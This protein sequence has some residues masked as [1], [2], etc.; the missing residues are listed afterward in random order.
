MYIDA[1]VVGCSDKSRRRSNRCESYGRYEAQG[2]DGEEANDAGREVCDPEFADNG[3]APSP[4][5]R[6]IRA[7]DAGRSSHHDNDQQMQAQHH[8][9]AFVIIYTF[10]SVH[11]MQ[12][13]VRIKRQISELSMQL[14]PT[15]Q[16]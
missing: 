16:T 7:V 1:D 11:F 15:K 4:L 13:V 9:L 12:T 6:G 10:F 14:S 8:A 3:S 2:E 5:M